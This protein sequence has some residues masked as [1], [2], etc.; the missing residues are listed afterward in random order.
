MLIMGK[1]FVPPPSGEDS[2]ASFN[3]VYANLP[4][5]ERRLTI[6]VIDD[7]P[8]SWEM[9]YREI[10][11]KTSLGERILEKLKKLEII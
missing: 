2:A 4:L 1:I 8:I 10:N 9:A 7:E 3:I 6:V 5:N 11:Q